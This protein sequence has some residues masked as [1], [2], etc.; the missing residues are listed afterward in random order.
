MDF[1]KMEEE[2]LLIHDVKGILKQL[3]R[4]GWE[5]LID[6]LHYDM[7]EGSSR[8]DKMRQDMGFKGDVT[9][10]EKLAETMDEYHGYRHGD[11]K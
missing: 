1:K 9:L 8:I 6:Q 10:L 11:N 7:G 4:S 5:A 2:D 3:S